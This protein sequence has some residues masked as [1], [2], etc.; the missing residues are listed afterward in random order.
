[1]GRVG[2]RGLRRVGLGVE[3]GGFRNQGLETGRFR[4]GDG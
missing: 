4:G 2:I 1:M 3:L